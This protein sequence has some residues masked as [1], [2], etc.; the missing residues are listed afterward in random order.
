MGNTTTRRRA[1]ASRTVQWASL[2]LRIG[3]IGAMLAAST[4]PVL[5]QD[6]ERAVKKIVDLNKKALG[7]IDAKKFDVARDALLQAESLAKQANLLTHKMLARTYVHLG[8]VYFLGYNDRKSALRYFGLAKS[9]RADIPMTPSLA[10]PNLTAVFDK[11]AAD[12]GED[13][14]PWGEAAASGPRSRPSAS[15]PARPVKSPPLDSSD[16]D[17]DSP[18]RAPPVAASVPDCPRCCQPTS[19]ARRWKRRRKVARL[20]SVARPNR[21]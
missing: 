20:S 9:V 19:T 13:N 7:A 5:G 2:A 1:G 12:T 8:A 18:S 16:S 15:P 11:A 6:D 3:L 21:R 17:S 14:D 4:T 10:T